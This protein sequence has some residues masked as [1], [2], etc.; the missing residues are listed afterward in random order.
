LI[1]LQRTP[2]SNLSHV[3]KSF[4]TIDSEN[5][6]TVRRQKIIPDGYPEII[7]HYKDPYRT[8]IDGHWQTQEKN[9]LAGQI[10][11]YFF[12]E[13]TG[14]SGMFAIKFQPGALRKLFGIKMSEI[15]DD[16][17]PINNELM[18]KML[19]IPEIACNADSF[20]DKVD[21]IGKVLIDLAVTSSGKDSKGDIAVKLILEKKG[22]ITIGEVLD[23]IHYSERSLERYFKEYIGL[24]P[25]FYC[26]II[27]FAHLFEHVQNHSP[28]LT[29]LGYLTGYYD[30]SHFIKNFKE[31]TGEDPSK[32]GFTDKNM[33]NFFLRK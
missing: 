32:Y 11:N 3:V 33:A 15:T 26:R 1:Y 30:Q 10:R 8:N 13:N 28:N 21:A 27:R 23:Q 6:N 20:D 9:L 24:S 29:S 25:K 14:Y 7:F 22:L 12:L 4:W 2:G 31:F 19:P 17:I 18:S 5:D 16:V